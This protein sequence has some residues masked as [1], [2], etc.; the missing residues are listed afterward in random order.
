MP[1]LVWGEVRVLLQA[2]APRHVPEPVAL[3]ALAAV[4]AAVT[5]EHAD[6]RRTDGE[7][8]V[9][10]LK[11]S[12]FE[13]GGF[14]GEISVISGFSYDYTFHDV[15][16]TW[17]SR[18]REPGNLVLRHSVLTFAFKYLISLS[19]GTWVPALTPRFALLPKRGNEN[20]N[21]LFP[22]VSIK[23][24]ALTVHFL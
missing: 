9:D 3:A 1:G 16:R 14:C 20:M 22:R 7:Q 24:V 10:R 11:R 6:W 4:R 19:R 18:Q 8:M 21:H 15:S 2:P 23:P 17:Q 13:Y 5:A 12:F